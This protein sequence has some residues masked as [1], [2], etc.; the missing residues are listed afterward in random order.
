METLKIKHTMVVLRVIQLLLGL[1]YMAAVLYHRQLFELELVH[2]T[3]EH[4]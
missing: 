2:L 4:N 3:C 1:D